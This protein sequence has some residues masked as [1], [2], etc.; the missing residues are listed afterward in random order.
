MARILIIDDETAITRILARVLVGH[1]VTTC[2]DAGSALDVIVRGPAF[3]LVLCDLHLD[4]MNGDELQRVVAEH[5]AEQARG[6]VFLTGDDPRTVAR[7]LGGE[8]I[9]IGKPF[10]LER[11]VE[12]ADELTQRSQGE[13]AMSGVHRTTRRTG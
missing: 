3:D 13:S 1:D 8:S 10:D 11:I 5:D 2:A 4:G 6:W 9:V 12:M 7:E